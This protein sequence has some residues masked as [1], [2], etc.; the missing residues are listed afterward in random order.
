MLK[1][2]FK[3]LHNCLGLLRKDKKTRVVLGK[4]FSGLR[5]AIWLRESRVRGFYFVIPLLCTAL[6]QS[7]ADVA[8]TSAQAFYNRHSLEKNFS[9]QYITMQAHQ[10]LYI[11]T[12]E[13]KNTHI[14]IATYHGDVLLAG[15]V[16]VAWQKSKA[17]QLIKDLPNVRQIYNLVTINT[18]SSTLTRMSDGWITAKIKAKLLTASDID[19]SQVK[20]VTENG[21][22]YLMGTVQPQEAATAVNIAKDTD[23]V[24]GVVKIFSYVTISK[25]K[26]TEPSPDPN[27]QA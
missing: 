12:D 25:N 22:V 2:N 6:L 13:F 11:K 9:D 4:I 17:E 14:A 27:P 15:Q 8:M 1:L 5:L 19:A 7:C 21:T 20:V 10:N 23:G 26:P 24:Q 16:P 3:L 18:P